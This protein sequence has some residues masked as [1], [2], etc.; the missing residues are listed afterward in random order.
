MEFWSKG[1]GKRRIVMGLT[2]GE[3]LVSEEALCL[4]GVMD[5]PVSWEYVML[6]TEADLAD[7]FDLLREPSLARY[8]HA[9]PNRWRLYSGLI[10]GALKITWLVVTAAV[11]QRFGWAVAEERVV[12]QLPPPYMVKKAKK[13]KKKPAYRR[14]LSTTTLAAPTMG[15]GPSTR[16]SAD[17]LEARGA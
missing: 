16:E 13:T 7:F 15:R 6:L 5:E 9:S 14:R 3:S 2:S 11:R 4:K 12:I 8:V 1:L 10:R 17:A